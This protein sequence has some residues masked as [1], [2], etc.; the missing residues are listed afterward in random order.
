MVNEFIQMNVFFFI[1]SIAMILLTIGLVV[2][3][4][5]IIIVIRKINKIVDQ[6]KE[7]AEVLVK[8]GE[9]TLDIVKTRT[10]EILSNDGLPQ[11][12]LATILGVIITKV[13]GKKIKR[14]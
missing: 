9:E 5:F 6:T 13:V 8:E 7:F 3:I 10:N 2:A 11:K 4:I 1:A 12:I 14:K